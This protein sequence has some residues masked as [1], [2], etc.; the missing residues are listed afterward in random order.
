MLVACQGTV[1]PERGAPAIQAQ[2]EVLPTGELP[3][4][5]LAK[6]LPKLTPELTQRYLAQ[7]APMLVSRELNASE[8]EQTENAKE[9][10]IAPILAN[11][12]AEPAFAQAARLLIEQKLGVSGNR[13]G[14]DF[15]LPGNLAEYVVKHE[16]P[17]T[18]FLTADYCVDALGQKRT[19]DTGAPFAA[20]VL[21]TRAYLVS[22]A[23]RFNLTRS[24]TMMRAFACRAYPLEDTLQP[25]IERTRLIPMFQAQ[26]PEEQTDPGAVNGFGNGF[27]CYTCHGQFSAHA[28]L[29]VKFDL[30]GLWREEA[31]GLQEPN[32]ELGR[33]KDGLFVSHLLNPTEAASERSQ[34]FG[35]PVEN[36]REAALTLAA[37]PV[38]VECQVR[39]VLEYA[40]HLDAAD[41]VSPAVM[42]EVGKKASEQGEPTFGSL[43]QATFTHPS[44]VEAVVLGAAGGSP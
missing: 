24:S 43:V 22:R 14:I 5:P 36:L 15:D 29:F 6:G 8:L 31:T 30:T 33:S 18:T 20:G 23:S 17:L 12:T 34:L 27:A 25:R 4:G 39:N 21:G 38:F 44:I 41:P 10:A 37:N 35:H 9:L 11:W 13:D 28:Q 16:L 40:L 3:S 7:L 2:D 42:V 1:L 19:C 26:S 32:E